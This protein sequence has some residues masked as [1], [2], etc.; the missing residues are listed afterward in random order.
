MK[1]VGV[2]D[3]L[4]SDGATEN[5]AV[6]TSATVYTKAFKLAYAE[7]FALFYKATSDGTVNVKIEIEQ[8]WRLPTTEGSADTSYVEPE[9]MS[10]IDTVTDET[11][12]CKSISPIPSPYA[13]LKLTGASDNDA[14]TT[15][16][17]RLSKQEDF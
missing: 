16:R 3:I 15:L 4:S 7:Y 2:S 11:Q 1:R 10:D 6:G 5:I 17:L 14:S 12:H 9:G 13:R 8:C